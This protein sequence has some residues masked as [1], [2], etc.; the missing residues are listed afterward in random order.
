MFMFHVMLT[1][2]TTTYIYKY[3][4][5]PPST[6]RPSLRSSNKQ[7]LIIWFIC[8]KCVGGCCYCFEQGWR[9]RR[10][11]VD[12][13]PLCCVDDHHRRSRGGTASA[14]ARQSVGMIEEEDK[15]GL[16]LVEFNSLIC[17]LCLMRPTIQLPHFILLS[18][19]QIVLVV[20]STIQMWRFDV[21]TEFNIG[22]LFAK[23]IKLQEQV[24]STPSLSHCDWHF[25]QDVKA[26]SLSLSLSRLT[27]L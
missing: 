24:N 25:T 23:H 7:T 19:L 13:F 20:L 5:P 3:A 11:V 8:C 26:L 21:S 18:S 2:T 16:C 1:T 17:I 27:L 12:A 4:L 22:K 10:G 15:E 6:S 14:A 9:I